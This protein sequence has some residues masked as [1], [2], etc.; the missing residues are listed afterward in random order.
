MK[1]ALLIIVSAAAIVALVL[2]LKISFLPGAQKAINLN[3]NANVSVP[4]G[5]VLNLSNKHLDKIPSYV[6]DRTD[7]EGL[8][9]SHNKLTGTIQS[10]IGQLTNLKILNASD[11]QMTGVPAEVGQLKNLLVLD[12]SNNKLTGLPNELRNLTKLQ[13]LDLRGNSYS[14]Q[15]LYLIRKSLIN[16]NILVDGA[17]PGASGIATGHV[18]LGPTCPVQRIPPDPGC[19]DKPY[20]TTVQAVAANSVSGAPFAT[21]ATDKNGAYKITLPPGEYALSAASGKMFPRCAAVNIIV[22]PGLASEI[23]LY[24]DTGIR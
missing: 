24:C 9:V 19:A 22:K 8:N 16:T 17:T 14:K 15:D 23:N 12:L 4:A 10:Q 18:L 6:F 3:G 2:L 21:T 5:K 1:K 11:N 7:L 20:Q 13:T